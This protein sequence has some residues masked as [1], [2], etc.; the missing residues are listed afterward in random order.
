MVS[1]GHISISAQLKLRLQFSILT[2]INKT[3][4]LKCIEIII[5]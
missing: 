4:S 1:F 5:I 3:I 2:K